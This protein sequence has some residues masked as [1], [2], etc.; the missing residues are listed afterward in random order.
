MEKTQQAKI[1]HMQ[2]IISLISSNLTEIQWICKLDIGKV[3]WNW[4]YPNA[5]DFVLQNPSEIIFQLVRINETQGI[6]QACFLCASDDSEFYAFVNLLI[7]R[8]NDAHRTLK[9][10]G[11]GDSWIRRGGGEVQKNI[12]Y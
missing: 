3:L 9:A 1:G 11:G 8:Q 6:S 7:C 5:L 12:F 10:G 2:V 4:L